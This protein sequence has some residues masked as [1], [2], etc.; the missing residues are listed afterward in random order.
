V[1][2]A[3]VVLIVVLAVIAKP[4]CSREDVKHATGFKQPAFA[5]EFAESA[6]GVADLY[7]ACSPALVSKGLDGDDRIVIPVYAS[8]LP[9]VLA[10]IFL[11]M[12]AWTPLPLRLAA[13]ALGVCLVGAAAFFDSRE[14]RTIRDIIGKT[15][16]DA[17]L[18]PLPRERIERVDLNQDLLDLRRA[19]NFKWAL[20]FVWF[21]V[22]GLMVLSRG[23]WWSAAVAVAC[24]AFAALGLACVF[25]NRHSLLEFT[26]GILLP[27]PLL[28]IGLWLALPPHARG[29][30]PAPKIAAASAGGDAPVS[31]GNSP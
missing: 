23:G 9:L 27:L 20:I 4:A 12:P 11:C 6:K 22:A 7:T 14:N 3:L 17:Q 16:A 1:L 8:L 2:V 24:L 28:L 15:T 5:M 18:T 10:L 31:V 19:T 29:D 13:L 30:E 25:A 26:F 21:T